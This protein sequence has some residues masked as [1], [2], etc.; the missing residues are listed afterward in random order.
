MTNGPDAPDD[1]ERLKAEIEHT[2]E[3]L[4]QT[5]EQLVA[6]ADV[7]ARAQ[8][9]VSGLTQRAKSATS[10]GIGGAGKHRTQVIIAVGALVAGVVVIRIWVR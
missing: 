6:K 1:A 2:R 4:G 10:K 9:K 3:Q 5:A 7:K 8:A